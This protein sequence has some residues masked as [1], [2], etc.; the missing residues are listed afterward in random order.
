MYKTTKEWEESQP[1]E[2]EESNIVFGG[3]RGPELKRLMPKYSLVPEKF[4]DHRG[5]PW[6]KLFNT[7]FFKELPEDTVF[8]SKDGIDPNK[9]FRHIKAV[10]KSWEPKHE[11]K[12]AAVAWL[13]SIWFKSVVSVE[14]PSINIE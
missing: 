3:A 4:Q 9:A 14:D 1:Q 8:D 11:H 7:M 6:N 12:E 13:L 5:T 2:V 10:M